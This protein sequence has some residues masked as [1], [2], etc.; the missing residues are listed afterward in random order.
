MCGSVQQ[1]SVAMCSDHFPG[2]QKQ[3]RGRQREG[4]RAQLGGQQ[5]RRGRMSDVSACRRLL[6]RPLQFWCSARLP[7]APGRRETQIRGSTGEAQPR[8]EAGEEAGSS[9]RWVPPQAAL[10]PRG[11]SRTAPVLPAP[12][13]HTWLSPAGGAGRRREQRPRPVGDRGARGAGGRGA[14]SRR[15]ARRPSDLPAALCPAPLSLTCLAA[16][17]AAPVTLTPPLGP[18]GRAR[19]PGVEA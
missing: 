18:A 11:P 2:D 6:L 13:A 3:R 4:G 16:N 1:M 17:G 14:R 7:Y 5:G 19:G 10:A 9:G 15:P 8:V 12:A